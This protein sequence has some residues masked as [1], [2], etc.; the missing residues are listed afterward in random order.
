MKSK[1][2]LLIAS[3]IT[4]AVCGTAFAQLDNIY[5]EGIAG[6]S[7]FKLSTGAFTNNPFT[8]VQPSPVG[9]AANTVTVTSSDKSD[10]ALGL[11]IGYHLNDNWSVEGSYINAGTA[12]VSGT[13][14]LN[15]PALSASAVTWSTE[16]DVTDWAFGFNY[17]RTLADKLSVVGRIA[18]GASTAEWGKTITTATIPPNS[19][20]QTAGKIL[21]D[22]FPAQQRKAG[23]NYGIT[24]SYKVNEHV[25]AAIGYD[26][27]SGK[28]A[29]NLTSASLKY[30]F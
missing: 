6:I 29:V 13:A 3:L 1:L 7:S 8:Q 30:S 16:L 25:S 5:A 20:A 23:F 2:R 28:Q 10:V 24:L 21:Q 17:R 15:T 4:S 14:Q 22:A 19:S 11:R 18:F 27:L 12:K 26:Y 9:T